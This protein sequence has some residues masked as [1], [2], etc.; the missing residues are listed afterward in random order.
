MHIIYYVHITANSTASGRP[1]HIKLRGLQS[2]NGFAADSYCMIMLLEAATAH[3]PMKTRLHTIS[4][5]TSGANNTTS[6]QNKQMQ[7]K[8]CS[9]NMIT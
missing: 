6:L 4:Y 1:K 8:P 7:Y 3:I 5:Q 9:K 2:R